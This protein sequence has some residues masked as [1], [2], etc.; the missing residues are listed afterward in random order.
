MLRPKSRPPSSA[1]ATRAYVDEHPSI[2]DALREDIVNFAFLARKIQ[3]ERGLTNEEAI[4]IALRRLQQEYRLATPDRAAVRSVLSRSRLEVRSRVAL[5]RIREDGATI[6]RLYQIGKGLLPE[7]RRRGVFQ[8]FQGTRALTILCED[9][10]LAELLGAIP[11]ANLISYERGLASVAFRSASD[12]SETPGVISTMAEVLFRQGINC[13]ESVSVH[14]DS[15]FVFKDSEVIR[16]Y[17]AL[18]NL[19]APA[20]SGP[21]PTPPRRTNSA[22]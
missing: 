19:I 15:I 17:A 6:D 16:A 11:E 21:P 3:A 22:S 7:L 2:R 20:E 8:M 12:V 14:N 9:D 1:D 10:L 4:E 13:L 5:L 18:S